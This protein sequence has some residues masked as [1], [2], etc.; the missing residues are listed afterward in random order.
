MTD[1]AGDSSRGCS[2]C[3]SEALFTVLDLGEV[4]L[5]GAFPRPEEESSAPRHPLTLM[6]CE[7]CF[8]VQ[9]KEGIPP[10]V[11]FDDYRYLAS[12]PLR[13]HFEE[14]AAHVPD[15]LAAPRDGL[16]VEIGCNDGVLLHPLRARGYLRLL[17]ID[18][19]ANV[20]ALVDPEIPVVTAFF[21]ADVAE[22]VVRDEGHANV[23]IA[24]NVFAHVADPHDFLDGVS[25][26]VGETGHFVFEVHYWYDLLEDVQFDTIYHEH[27]Y[28]YTLT[29]LQDMLS[30]HQLVLND[31]ENIGNH[32]GS[33]RVY[34]SKRRN[35]SKA[36]VDALTTEAHRGVT[37][38]ESYAEFTH[39]VNAVLGEL[40]AIAAALPSDAR[41]AA[42][43]A[44]GRAVTFLNVARQLAARI[45]YVVDDS[46]ERMGRVIPGVNIPIVARSRLT[47]E[48]P[49]ALV[50]TAWTYQDQILGAVDA[51][52]GGARPRILVPLPHPHWL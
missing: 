42:Y 19:A 22:S 41:V 45:S 16:I 47:E 40:D 5:A 20:T 33:V 49:S 44:A 15:Q 43:G 26:L 25:R 11:M 29:V 35:S 38:R 24:N 30:R 7:V 12:I 52:L 8:L 28:Y 6:A 4:P 2:N 18:P 51:E 39:R 23:V 9:V 36:V 3:G 50:L 48:P 27:R 14:F 21:S 32:G 34:A 13:R 1:I 46:P 31:V 37:R 10:E 17:G